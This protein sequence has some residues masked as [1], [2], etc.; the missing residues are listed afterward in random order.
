MALRDTNFILVGHELCLV[1][2]K[3]RNPVYFKVAK[4]DLGYN[5][6]LVRTFSIVRRITN[7]I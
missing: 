3:W 7:D 6:L 1:H 4:P 2:I 5:A